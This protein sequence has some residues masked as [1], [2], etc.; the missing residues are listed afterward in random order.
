MNNLSLSLLVG[1]GVAVGV[2]CCFLEDKKM[3]KRGQGGQSGS[4]E[5]LVPGQTVVAAVSADDN[6][7]A[8]RRA[9]AKRFYIRGTKPDTSAKKGVRVLV[10]DVIGALCLCCC[11][12]ARAAR[13]PLSGV[14]G[15]AL[16]FLLLLLFSLPVVAVAVACC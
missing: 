14:V 1:A 7:E 16:L 8:P 3:C 2:A 11:W 5:L 10:V 15:V 12:C 9:R 6:K 4:V 13:N